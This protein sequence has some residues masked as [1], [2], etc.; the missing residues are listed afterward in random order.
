[1][2][3]GLQMLEAVLAAV[4]RQPGASELRINQFDLEDLLKLNAVELRELDVADEQANRIV[5]DLSKES[6]AEL[7]EW[8]GVALVEDKDQKN[9]IPG[10]G[11][12]RTAGIWADGN[13]DPDAIVE[14]IRRLRNPTLR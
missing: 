14:E 13:D 9:L 5:T 3:T 11:I 1:M 4:K 12:R 7:S 8:I 6:L 2:A 10:E